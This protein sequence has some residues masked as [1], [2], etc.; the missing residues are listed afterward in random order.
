MDEQNRKKKVALY[1][2]V[3]TDEQAD[4]YGVDLQRSAL[5]GLIASK[6]HNLEFAGDQYVY[7]DE[8]VS[9]TVVPAERPAFRRL[10][11]DI[12]RSSTRPFDVVA[13]YKID[14][15]A[16]RLKVLLDILDIFDKGEEKIEFLSANE[17][18][19]TSTPFGRAM[20]GI[21]GVIAELEL[22]NIKERTSDG[23]QSSAE[24]GTYM[25]IPPL[26][27]V[28]GIDG[29]IVV[30][31]EESKVVQLIFNMY[32]LEGRGVQDIARYLRNHK[33]KSPQTF[34]YEHNKE[35]KGNRKSSKG[36]PYYWDSSAVKAVLQN[37]LYIGIQY[38]NKTK[39]GKKL[40]KDQWGVYYHDQELIDK[41]TFEKAQKYILAGRKSYH[42]RQSDNRLYLLQGLLK[43]ANCFDPTLN[44]EPYVWN[45]SPHVVKSTG[46]KSYY[47]SCSSKHS[48]KK[49]RRK[50]DCKALPLP[51]E[52]LEKHVIDFIRTLLNNPR[53]V[54]KYQQELQSK[55]VDVRNKRD[56][57]KMIKE[58]IN[59]NESAKR[60]VQIMYRDGD[61][62][63]EQKDKELKEL[64]AQLDRNM[65]EKE[66]LD[67][68]LAIYTNKEE[69][70][71]AF[72]LFQQK[73]EE[74]MNEYMQDGNSEY[75]YKLIHMMIE[76]VIVFSRPK[77]KTDSIS[78]PKKEGQ[79][80]PYKLNI[81]LKIPSEMLSDLLF[82][83][84]PEAKL[85]AEKDGWWAIR[86]SNL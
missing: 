70:F 71:K 59:T 2:R 82:S 13:V 27:Y 75:L 6:G 55:K 11:E 48:E 22:E 77:R 66:A 46:N 84:A 20:L 31:E 38:Y 37:E 65:R 41:E 81:V 14:R 52:P 26:G 19:D 78:G 53:A 64:K 36:G 69:Y 74:A 29:K 25:N 54:F 24:K 35:N 32:V 51:A 7:I 28:K 34:R 23:R 72:E 68:E 44:A 3:S 4:M 67:T 45:G 50:I 79:M 49:S 5:M 8:G 63:R 86:D 73:Y 76:E 42:A 17:S 18:I 40:Q 1:I 83:L 30:Q 10:M 15:F 61:I 43:C 16:R 56:K 58:L 33:V 60:R 80:V 21:I 85:Q 9:G 62:S 39:N 47:Y 57:L 12:S